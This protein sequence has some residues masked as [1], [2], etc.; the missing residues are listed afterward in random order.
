MKTLF[1][2][3]IYRSSKRANAIKVYG[4]YWRYPKSS[5]IQHPLANG[6]RTDSSCQHPHENRVPLVDRCSRPTLNI[7]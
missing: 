7:A 3:P 6:P 1:P 2:L 4:R 5:E